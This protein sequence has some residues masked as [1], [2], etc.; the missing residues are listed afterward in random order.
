MS[1]EITANSSL[2]YDD[3]NGVVHTME[4]AN[5]QISPANPKCH[6]TQQTIGTIAE[7]L[8]IGDISSLGIMKLRNLS[9]V[10]TVNVLTG[11]SGVIFATMFPRD[12]AAG[13]DYCEIQVGSGIT[14]PYA[15]AVTA[16]ADIDI[17]I[18]QL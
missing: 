1:L 15:Q 18:T 6:H 11:N 4:R 17:M 13:L 3:G 2:E 9:T 8:D 5:R 16:A 14:A 12:S 7:A 10:Y